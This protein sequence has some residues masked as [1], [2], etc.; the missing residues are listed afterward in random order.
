MR[1]PTVT[2]VMTD[3]V[4]SISS[5]TPF[6]EIVELLIKHNISAVPVVDGD[7]V[8]VGVV[9]EAD[10]MSKEEFEGGTEPRPLLAGPARRRRWR[11]S[12]GTTAA[13]LMHR[14]VLT[15]RADDL[16]P[17]AARKLAA[18]G[19]RRLF[20]VDAAG[21]LVGVVS[22]RDLLTLYLRSDE[23]L[24]SEIMANVLG[25][26]LWIEDDRV[27]VTVADG[28]V[29]LTG[30]LPRRSEADVTARL[31]RAQPGVIGVVDHL[32][33]EYDDLAAAGAGAL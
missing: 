12:T 16:V 13:D 25:A 18:A 20:V 11:Q 32:R 9:S 24:A 28:V 1:S 27:Q 14:P 2:S 8:P 26:A 29:T 5:E 17:V 10:L 4:I 3:E 31:T 19:V 22:R 23:Q 33:Y 30:T 6:K 15:V 21:R 7:G